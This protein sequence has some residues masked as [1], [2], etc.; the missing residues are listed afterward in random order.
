MHSSHA[1]VDLVVEPA[2]VSGRSNMLGSLSGVNAVRAVHVGHD[3]DDV[4]VH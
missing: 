3:E 4:Y 1:D 2:K